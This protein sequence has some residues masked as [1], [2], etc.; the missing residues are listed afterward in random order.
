VLARIVRDG[1]RAA[2][3][4]SRV[5]AGFRKRPSQSENIEVNE[6]IRELIRLVET[7]LK[8]SDVQCRTDLADDLPGVPGDRVQFD[9]VLLNL[10]TNAIEAMAMVRG[11]LREL[12][13]V[14][15]HDAGH[16][17]VEVRDTGPGFDPE[18]FGELFNSFYTTKP[19][20]MGMGLAICRSII[21]AH[22][23]K[24]VAVPNEP[25]G[26]VFRFALPAARDGFSNGGERSATA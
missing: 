25:H 2:E 26:A 6:S 12:T 21:E 22:G 5:R 9:Q 1:N 17:V 10:I 3:V 14:T 23:G 8:I 19:E 11:R 4:I 7:E 24:I 16:V 18:S 15:A 20:G 13:V